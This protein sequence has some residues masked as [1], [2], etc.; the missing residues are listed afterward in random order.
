M[1]KAEEWDEEAELWDTSSKH[2][3]DRR[4]GVASTRQPSNPTKPTGDDRPGAVRFWIVVL[5]LPPETPLYR[6]NRFPLKWKTALFLE[7]GEQAWVCGGSLMCGAAQTAPVR[8][9]A[10]ERH[11]AFSPPVQKGTVQPVK[12]NPT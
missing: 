12:V 11:F 4:Q 5:K 7:R 9:G 1:G 8:T 3:E 6:K 2:A 10:R